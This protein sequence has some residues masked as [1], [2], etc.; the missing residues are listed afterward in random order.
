MPVSAPFT[1]SPFSIFSKGIPAPVFQTPVSTGA[2]QTTYNAPH[3][4]NPLA[5]GWNPF[6]SGPTTL[7]PVAGGNPAFTFVNKGEIPSTS[8]AHT[9]QAPFRPKIPFLA[10]FNFPD[11]SK[12]MNDLV[13]HDAT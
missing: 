6:Q 11:L 2:A 4:N 12:L 10:T 1:S 5:Y 8:Q 7:Q 3:I 13:K 9:F